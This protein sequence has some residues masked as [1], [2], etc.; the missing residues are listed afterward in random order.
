[1][2]Q[3][4]TDQRFIFYLLLFLE[5]VLFN[6]NSDAQPNLFVL[7]DYMHFCE[8]KMKFA[9][10]IR[11]VEIKMTQLSIYYT[12]GIREIRVCIKCSI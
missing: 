2:P 12:T 7:Q 9:D 3:M 10:V 4:A 5:I 1:M 11:H 8:T 6:Q